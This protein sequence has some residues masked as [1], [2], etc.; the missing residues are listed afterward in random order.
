MKCSSRIIEKSQVKKW[1][2]KNA[3]QQ[4]PF[5]NNN[6]ITY[7]E[8]S[9]FI[10]MARISWDHYSSSLKLPGPLAVSTPPPPPMLK[11][12]SII[13]NNSGGWGIR[14]DSILLQ[15]GIL[16]KGRADSTTT[17]TTSSA[18]VTEGTVT[19]NFGLFGGHKLEEGRGSKED[20]LLTREWEWI[21][22]YNVLCFVQQVQ[23]PFSHL[24]KNWVLLLLW[25]R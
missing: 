21:D 16:A 23:F 9:F 13:W 8:S 17:T 20:E 24:Q 7:F 3:W 2:C 5:K 10:S 15:T 25:E 18:P 11:W 6:K 1:K 12:L 14:P 22:F 19:Y 4:Q